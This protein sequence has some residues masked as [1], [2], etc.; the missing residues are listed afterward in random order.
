MTGVKD[1]LNLNQNNGESNYE[2][3][4]G[5]G[6][7]VN[8]K[9]MAV[10][11]MN[12]VDDLSYISGE[13][14]FGYDNR[15][16]SVFSAKVA[17]NGWDNEINQLR[18]VDAKGEL[19]VGNK[20]KGEKSLLNGTVKDVNKFNLKANL[21][22]SRDKVNE[23]KNQS[24]F[25]NDYLQRLSDNFY[26]QRF[27]YAIKSQISYDKWKEPIK[28][29]IHPSGFKEFS[30]LDIVSIPSSN[31]KVGISSNDLN[32]SVLMDNIQSLYTKNNFTLVLEDDDNLFEDGSIERIN[33]GAEEGNIAGVGTFGPIFGVPLK[34][35][36]L[37][38]TN[39][40][41]LMNDISDQFDGSND[42]ISIGTTTA[43]FNALNQYY[44]GISTENLKIGD[45]IGNS[46]FLIPEATLVD[47]IGINSIR[48]NLPHRLQ[49]G[50]DTTDVSIRR[51]LPGNKVVGKTSFELTSGISSEKVPLYYR[52]F[53]S[54]S[55]QILNLDNNII[56]L[57]SH[58]FQTGQ[59]VFYN[60]SIISQTPVGSATTEVD[61]AFSYNVSNKFDSNTIMRF[62][63]TIF[64][65][66]SN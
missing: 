16:N 49:V 2:N 48:I 60:Q 35:Y 22:V 20:L 56:N 7:V 10:F 11:E 12:L 52:E 36:I 61:N 13:N 31:V 1:S 47:E 37:N 38:K 17:E 32:L 27:S 26:Y 18:M 34:E 30:D 45:Y 33:V 21:G 40:V 3:G 19:E 6:Y 15:G 25:L 58:N 28:S 29:L 8:K 23:S 5:Y 59:R 9:D 51:K 55:S 50:I 63:M 57:K 39:K 62:D 64:K 41:L 4:F 24:G 53:N 46:E 42:Y 44:V 65:F 66:D 43:T 14:V 54:N